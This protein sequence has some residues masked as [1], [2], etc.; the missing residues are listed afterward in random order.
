MLSKTILLHNF[1]LCNAILTICLA[2]LKKKNL[3]DLACI[4]CICTLVLRLKNWKV[5]HF[6]HSMIHSSNESLLPYKI[7]YYDDGRKMAVV[8]KR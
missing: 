5:K 6:D 8:F 1:Y 2:S 7:S 3:K 4:I